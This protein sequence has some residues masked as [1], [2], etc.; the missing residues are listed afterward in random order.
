MKL[1]H[2]HKTGCF[3]FSKKNN[4]YIKNILISLLFHLFSVVSVDI[5]AQQKVAANDVAQANNPL[6]KFTAFNVH[7]YYIGELTEVNKNAHQ[8]WMRF[9]TPFSIGKSKWLLRASLPISSF[10]VGPS[11]EYKTGLGDLLI[12]PQYLIPLGKPGISFGFGPQITV[13]SATVKELGTGKWSA[14]LLNM[15]FNYRSKKLQWGYLVTWQASFAGPDDRSNVNSGGIQPFLFYQLGKG[16]YLRS[17]AIATFNFENNTYSIPI[18]LG[19]GQV[20][21]KKK[22]IFNLFVEPQYSVADKGAGYPHW[23]IFFGL[24]SQFK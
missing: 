14:G 24:N 16:R 6:A 1:N 22:V 2:N 4:Q 17:S 10:P 5:M 7:Y 23:E 13:P 12:Q 18:G 3:H 21:P 20:I 19:F 9:A 15:L 8:G 11:L